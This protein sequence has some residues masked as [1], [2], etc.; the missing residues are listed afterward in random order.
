MTEISV[1]VTTS[2]LEDQSSPEESRFV[3]GYTINV[4]NNSADPAQLI[5]RHWVVTD[6]NEEVQEVKGEG[7]VGKQPLIQ[8]GESFTYS[9]GVIL[10][11]DTGSMRGSYQM[12]GLDG[13]SFDVEI[14]T[15]VLL[16][17]HKLH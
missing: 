11:T 4:A 17:P 6:A 2:Y 12:Q 1:R 10:P 15:F 3:F 8:P 13:S 14:P 16:P 7:V 5:S 9:S